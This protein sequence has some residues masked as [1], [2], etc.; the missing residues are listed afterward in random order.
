M[1]KKVARGARIFPGTPSQTVCTV[2]RSSVTF[3]L[4]PPLPKIRLHF[5]QQAQ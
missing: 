2:Q 3:T 4:F 5:P 1:N